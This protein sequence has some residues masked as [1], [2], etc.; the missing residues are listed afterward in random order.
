MAKEK[1]AAPEGSGNT[2]MT[3]T[4]YYPLNILGKEVTQLTMRRAKV[5][6]LKA[7][8]RMANGNQADYEVALAA[9]LSGYVVEDFEDM[10]SIDYEQVQDMFRR[11]REPPAKP[12]AVDGSA[13]E[14][15]QVPTE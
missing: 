10:D 3:I 12:V 5:R 6:D 4:L 15:V 13:G 2:D 1:A 14:T 11:F 8:Q 7:A 9:V